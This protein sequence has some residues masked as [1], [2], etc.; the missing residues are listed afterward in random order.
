MQNPKTEA[1]ADAQRAVAADPAS[2]SAY[3]SL[4]LA[5]QAGF[6]LNAALVAA[7]KAVELDPANP[8]ALVQESSLLFGMGRRREATQVAEQARQRA[9]NDAMVNTVW[10]F[11]ES[12]SYTHLDVYKRQVLHKAA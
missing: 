1:L 9:P 7:Q 6:D 12:V 5:H 10:G 4:S 2:S 8:R 11:M 3:L